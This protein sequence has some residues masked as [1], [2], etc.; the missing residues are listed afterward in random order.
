ML[1]N[2]GCAKPVSQR[3]Q[4]DYSRFAYI[5]HRNDVAPLDAV[6][7]LSRLS[8]CADCGEPR[9]FESWPKI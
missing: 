7:R 9:F 3:I 4:A 2:V 1:L 6:P 8:E 5:D